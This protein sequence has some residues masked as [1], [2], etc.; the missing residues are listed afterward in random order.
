M[1]VLHIPSYKTSHGEE[2]Q[3]LTISC[4]V[5]KQSLDDTAWVQVTNL[6]QKPLSHW[7]KDPSRKKLNHNKVR[8]NH[9]LINFS[10]CICHQNKW[11]NF[12]IEILHQRHFPTQEWCVS[13]S[14]LFLLVK[15]CRHVGMCQTYV[16]IGK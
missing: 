5:P 6:Q 7:H 10:L 2:N 12:T 16:L 1:L 8:R 14:K 9:L 4:N 13:Q 15:L 3:E 11:S